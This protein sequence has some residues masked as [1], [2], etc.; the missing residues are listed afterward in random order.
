MYNCS[1]YKWSLDFCIVLRMDIKQFRVI[2]V[3]CIASD[4]IL[5]LLVIG[6]P[7]LYAPIENATNNFQ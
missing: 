4:I 1:D 7:L 6:F 5:L 2:G 3:L